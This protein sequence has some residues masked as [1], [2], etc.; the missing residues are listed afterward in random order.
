MNLPSVEA[1]DAFVAFCAA[2]ETA[3]APAGGPPM[4]LF[5]G[6]ATFDEH[7]TAQAVADRVG[8]VRRVSGGGGAG[9]ARRGFARGAFDAELVVADAH[10][11][12]TI[13]RAFVRARVREAAGYHPAGGRGRGGEEGVPPAGAVRPRGGGEE[14]AARASDGGVSRAVRARDDHHDAATRGG[15][16]GL[17]GGGRRA[18]GSVPLR[19]EGA[20]RRGHSGGQV[21]GAR[22]A[23][24]FRP[25]G[26]RGGR[27]RRRRGNR[28]GNRGAGG[29]GRA[30][31]R[32][33]RAVPVRRLAR[34][35]EA[36]EQA[37]PRAG[38]R[39]GGRRA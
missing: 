2:N 13:P 10:G 14:G 34:A 39:R 3:V 24:G 38:R 20:V 33:A 4:T 23:S 16:A 25:R 1:L 21:P 29:A 31:R 27:G 6:P 37:C 22:R 12:P 35:F 15:R 18:R 17:R 9:G 30:R 19:L 36:R 11:A 7:E 5:L 8:R 32:V 26:G 28:G